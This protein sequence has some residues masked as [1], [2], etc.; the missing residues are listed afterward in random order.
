MKSR[1]WREI[2]NFSSN[3]SGSFDSFSNYL[4]I[5]A[6]E[7]EF[8]ETRLLE[9]VEIRDLDDVCQQ[10]ISTRLTAI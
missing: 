6:L 10:F 9:N 1:T 7:K 5:N 8:L 3:F 4:V 2:S